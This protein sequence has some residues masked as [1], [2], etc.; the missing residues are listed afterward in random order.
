[1]GYRPGGFSSLTFDQAVPYYSQR[2]L[3]DWNAI[4]ILHWWN[5]AFRLDVIPFQS[6]DVAIFVVKQIIEHDKKWTTKWDFKI[7]LTILFRKESSII[8]HVQFP[9]NCST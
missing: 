2:H 4:Y 9:S 8:E 7:S 5:C 3:A 1:M 6:L